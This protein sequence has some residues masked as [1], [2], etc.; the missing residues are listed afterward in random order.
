[1]GGK[2]PKI[3][4]SSIIVPNCSPV[5]TNAQ[6]ILLDYLYKEVPASQSLLIDGGSHIQSATAYLQICRGEGVLEMGCSGEGT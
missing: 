3:G 1:M 5:N 6:I 2:S 4:V